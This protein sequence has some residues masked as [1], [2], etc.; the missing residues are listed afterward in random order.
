MEENKRGNNRIYIAIISL[1]LLV[2]GVVGFLLY[3]ENKEKQ[4]KIEEV[5]KYANDYRELNEQFATTKLELET[6]KGK[7]AELDSIIQERQEKI[8][9]YQAELA[10][11]QR[12]GKLNAAE[13][14]RYKD[15]IA[16]L[17]EE[18]T[19][20]QKR[21]SELTAQN[22]ELTVQNLELDKNLNAEKQTTAV[23][24]QE[25]EQLSKK[26]VLGS[27]LQLKALKAEG[28]AKKKSGKEV[29]KNRLKNIDYL[30]ISFN[31][32]EN[33]VLEEG[34]LTL[35]LRIINPKGET[36]TA[37]EQGSGML[38]L[39]DGNSVPFSKK[40]ETEWQKTSKNIAVEW[41]QN[42][43][44]SGTY[45]IEIYQSGYEVGSGSVVLK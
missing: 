8:E 9:K 5:G 4:E 44:E 28:V 30:K 17:Q 21:V 43:I 23:L 19:T 13:L 14:R 40:I 12:E 29:A 45:K 38:T 37:T 36:I 35:Y 22:Q 25:K 11:A 31:T 34:L 1:L 20:L 32:G 26:V 2:D 3:K 27:L 18:N 10:A 41:S 42:L 16:G 7:N 6:L 33:K 39:A 24:S 15:L